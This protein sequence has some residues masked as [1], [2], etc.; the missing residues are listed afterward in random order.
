[1]K[2][3]ILVRHGLTDY[4]VKGLYQ[5]HSDPPLNKEGRAQIKSLADGFADKEPQI[6]FSSPLKR[7]LKSAD[8]LN[9]DL[10]LEIIVDDRIKEI[11]FGE[12]EG[13]TYDEIVKKYPEAFEWWKKDMANFRP[14]G[15]ESLAELQA[16]VREF[17]EEIKERPED[18]I[19]VVA[20]GGVI[21]A[22]MVELM[23]VPFDSFWK[24]ELS[25][26][27]MTVIDAEKDL[28]VRV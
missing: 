28:K 17:F 10:D 3:L 25:P 13:E 7:A 4:L 8:I 20:H 27:S 15:G 21:R 12:W 2:K 1:M 9:K 22:F 26:A 23:G 5:G 14:E 18:V 16:R 19:A 11:S 6:I 24:F